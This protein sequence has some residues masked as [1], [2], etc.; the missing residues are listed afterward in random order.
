MKL[1]QNTLKTVLKLYLNCFVFCHYTAAELISLCGQFKTNYRGI[2]WYGYSRVDRIT[3]SR[4]C[5]D[6]Q[7]AAA[8]ARSIMRL[9]QLHSQAP[10]VKVP[11]EFRSRKNPQLYMTLPKWKFTMRPCGHWN[12]NLVWDVFS[13]VESSQ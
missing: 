3:W 8:K 13:H 10:F 9:H 11:V 4:K 2:T 5:E 12:C 6:L 7:T 1:K